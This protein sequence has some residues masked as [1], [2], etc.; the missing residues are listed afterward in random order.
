MGIVVYYSC[1]VKDNTTASNSRYL[2]DGYGSGIYIADSGNRIE[3]NN[4]NSDGDGITA[5]GTENIIVRNTVRDAAQYNYNIES[6]NMVGPVVDATS[7]G[8]IQGISGGVGLGT[9][10]PNANFSY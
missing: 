2:D 4:S 6:G 1:L 8:A 5:Y 10:D 3:G 7:S 9:T